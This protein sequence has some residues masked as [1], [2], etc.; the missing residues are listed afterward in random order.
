MRRSSMLLTPAA[1]LGAAA[2]ALV[3][4]IALVPG[5]ARQVALSTTRQ[6][7]PFVELYFG[8]RGDTS[9][10]APAGRLRVGFTVAS[11]L[12]SSRHLAYTLDV[13]TRA[14]REIRRN[15][16]VLLAAGRR[17]DVERVLRLR[18]ARPSEVLVRLPGRNEQ[19]R[20]RCASPR[21][22]R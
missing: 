7:A 15:G 20:L 2:V 4:A 6:P 3:L 5:V 11:H 22:G 8:A 13:R 10:P 18:G 9:C 12:T 21:A 1:L 17:A 19:I 14:G 16:A